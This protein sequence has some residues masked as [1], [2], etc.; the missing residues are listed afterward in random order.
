VAERAVL[1]YD[2]A[3]VT[4]AQTRPPTQTVPWQQRTDLTIR[5]IDQLAESGAF[6]GDERRLELIDGRLVEMASRGRRHEVVRTELSYFF[7]RTASPSIMV[8]GEPQFN[9][10]DNLFRCPDI[11]LHPK[12]IKTPEVKGPTALLV[13]EV[14]DTT[15]DNDLRIKPQTYAAHGVREYWVI[16]AWTLM[17]TVHRDPTATGYASITTVAG[18]TVLAPL[19]IPEL[20]VQLDQLDL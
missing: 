15:L 1:W 20:A 19:L 9:L 17:T 13:I 12:S 11:M 3:M 10:A 14:A 2:L 18:N 4:R 5:D 16:E 7:Y 8:V 6:I